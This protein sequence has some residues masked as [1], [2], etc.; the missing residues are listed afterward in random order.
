MRPSAQPCR[1]AGECAPPRRMPGAPQSNAR[2]KSTFTEAAEPCHKRRALGLL[3][4]HWGGRRFLVPPWG[5]FPFADEPSL[6]L[7][8]REKG[9]HVGNGPMPLLACAI[10]RMLPVPGLTGRLSRRSDAPPS[11]RGIPA[12]AG[13]S[14]SRRDKTTA[15]GGPAGP[16]G[17]VVSPQ[18]AGQLPRSTSCGAQPCATVYRFRSRGFPFDLA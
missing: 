12:A 13:S 3:G 8:V 18:P 5:P 15:V 17:W 7:L 6:R 14:L 2:K 1:D 10:L 11:G 4:E 16:A 9:P